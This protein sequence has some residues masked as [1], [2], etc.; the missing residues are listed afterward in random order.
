METDAILK[1][2]NNLVQQVEEGFEYPLTAY[3]IL[4][5]LEDGLNAAIDKIKDKA[6]DEAESYPEKDFSR[7]GF[8]VT[9]RKAPTRWIYDGIK[10]IELAEEK[11]KNL[12]K[13]AQY[14]GVDPETGELME[15]TKVL[16]G[17]TI[18]IKKINQ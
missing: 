8:L 13:L 16:G 3:I 12:K 10:A 17:T 1:K 4:K 14:G 5:Q 9:K 6:I 15:A 2:I 18:V 7:N 11:L